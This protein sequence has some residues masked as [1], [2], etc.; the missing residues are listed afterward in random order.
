MCQWQF[1]LVQ[2]NEFLK[3]GGDQ[4]VKYHADILGRILPCISD[5]EEKIQV[6]RRHLV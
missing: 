6:V 1:S 2:I 4:L 5:E 3:L